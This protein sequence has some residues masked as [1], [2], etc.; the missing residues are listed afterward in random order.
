MSNQEDI[1]L[2][3]T[4]DLEFRVDTAIEEL[5]ELNLSVIEEFDLNNVNNEDN[6]SPETSMSS[7]TPVDTGLKSIFG[8][9]TALTDAELASSMSSHKKED[10]KNMDAKTLTR[11]RDN[12]TKTL[13]KQFKIQT[14]LGT[15]GVVGEENPD[16][17]TTEIAV[18]FAEN[19]HVIEKLARVLEEFDMTSAIEVRLVEDSTKTHPTEK[20]GTKV[21][22]LLRSIG[23]L[24]LDQVKEYSGDVMLYDKSGDDGV[25][26][27]NLQWLL[28]LIRNN[29]SSSIASLI[30]PTFYKLEQKYKN[31]QYTSR[32]YLIFAS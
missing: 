10:R 23:E 9:T 18:V 27:Q 12:A 29:T 24:D 11:V 28:M 8:N 7:S 6:T 20:Y 5:E 25:Y 2:N 15:S 22:D 3:E 4:I 13:D 26:R 17:D 16:L 32:W 1:N 14:A 30:E 21:I 31:G 19:T